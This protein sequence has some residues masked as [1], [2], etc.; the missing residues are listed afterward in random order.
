MTSKSKQNRYKIY[1]PFLFAL[2]LALG[3]QLGFKLYESLKGKPSIS[4]AGGTIP[5]LSEVFGYIDRKYVAD[6]D[7]AE[8]VENAIQ[9][10]LQELDPHSYYISPEDLVAVTED[11]QG[12]FEGIGVEFNI[13]NDTITVITPIAGGPSEKLGIAAGDK[14]ISV[15]DSLIAG[16]GITNEGVKE[17][18]RGQKGS[19]V[20]VSIYRKGIAELLNFTI[21]RDKIPMLSV[22]ADFMMDKNTG[23]I[24][25]NRFS[26]T[27]FNEFM[28]STDRLRQQGMNQLVIDLRQNPGGYLTSAVN[29]ADE[30]IDGKKLIVYTEGQNYKRV[31]HTARRSG[32]LENNKICILIDEGSASASE[33]L[34]GAIQDWDRGTVVG[35]R[36]FGKGLVQ[37]QFS[38]SNG[39][40]FR[41]T[42]ARYY[43]PSG[44]CIQ[45]PYDLENEAEYNAE[46][47][48]RISNGELENEDSLNNVY[49]NDSLVYTTMIKGREVYGG[50]GIAPDIFVPIDTTG[51]EAFTIKVRS[52]IPQFCYDYF[53]NHKEDIITYQ[54]LS[55]FKQLF[56]VN[57]DVVAAFKAHVNQE[58]GFIDEQLFTQYLPRF[59][60]Y[61]KAY[62]AKQQWSY[63]GM[64]FILQDIDKPLQEAYKVLS[65]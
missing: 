49:Q 44:R 41:L 3:L 32:F 12:N 40:A 7:K 45:K 51:N 38:L 59:K 29:I 35:R 24:K 33:I 30:I 61:I 57:N 13:I 56:T 42:I 63:N 16:V 53:S 27:T 50:G 14:I 39:G 20:N 54:E 52:L 17:M 36:S 48:Q 58:I 9:E 31:N 37:E 64:Y 22:D 5:E 65:E 25:I 62:F 26:S 10:T 6:V 60:T 11:L 34:A 18:L 28:E 15:E 1:L 21:T 43:T 2:V 47:A 4:S 23:Y 19:K 8:L 46:I 55:D